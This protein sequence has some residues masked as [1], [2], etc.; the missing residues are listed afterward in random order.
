MKREAAIL[1]GDAITDIQSDATGTWKRLPIQKT[2]GNAYVRS[3]YTAEVVK[4]RDIM[5]K[6]IVKTE[7][8]VIKE[9]EPVEEIDETSV[10]EPDAVLEEIDGADIDQANAEP[11]EDEE[12]G[13]DA[14]AP[15][16]Y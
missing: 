5:T 7:A 16:A 10:E 1:G 4:C 6:P 15:L 2:I 14:Q 8:I 3:N 11:I 9:T 12:N 13:E